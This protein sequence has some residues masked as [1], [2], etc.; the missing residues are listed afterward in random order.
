[1]L[2]ELG[3]SLK[4][5]AG[6]GA[7]PAPPPELTT[8][9]SGTASTGG[10]TSLTWSH[11]MGVNPGYSILL[12]AIT[13]RDTQSLGNV[14]SAITYN[15]LPLTQLAT[16]SDGSETTELHYLLNPPAGA[17]DV[18]ASFSGTLVAI[19]GSISWDGVK[20][21]GTFGTPVTAT[22]SNTSITCAITIAAGSALIFAAGA[23]PS[24]TTTGWTAVGNLAPVQNALMGTSPNRTRGG[25]YFNFVDSGSLTPTLTLAAAKPWDCIAVEL[26]P[27][28]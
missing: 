23:F 12:V 7:P 9:M 13:W 26:K 1:M 24:T 10:A 16:K 22:G 14:V 21:S 8:D 11:T 17:H 15:G 19:A 4:P 27:A 28:A 20:Q 2:F 6:A 3:L 5:G 18:V 25:M